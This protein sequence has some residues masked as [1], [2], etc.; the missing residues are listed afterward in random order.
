M[1]YGSVLLALVPVLL[2]GAV[3]F[4]IT[5]RVQPAALR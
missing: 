3:V 2:V 4:A 5:S 1:S